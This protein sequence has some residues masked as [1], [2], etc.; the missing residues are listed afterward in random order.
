MTHRE[1]FN[2]IMHYGD[3]DRIPVIHWG[4]WPETIER[5]QAEGMPADVEQQE[6]FGTV[7][8]WNIL[9]TAIDLR[10]AFEVETIEENDRYRIYRNN[11][12]VICKEHRDGASSIPH[13][14]DYTFKDASNWPEFKRRLQPEPSRIPDNTDEEIDRLIAAEGPICIWGGSIMGLI[15]NWMGVENM[16][17]LVMDDPDV[18]ADMTMTMADLACWGFD[19]VLPRL[20]AKGETADIAFLWEDMCGRQGPLISPDTFRR[21]VAPAYRKMREKLDGYGVKLF[22]LDSDGDVR[23]L[24]RDWVD[25]GVNVMFPLEVG[26]MKMDAN[27]IRRE[28]GKELRLVGNFDKMA[29]ERG[30]ADVEAE[31]QRLMPLIR[32]GGFLMSPDHLITPGV[33]LDAYKAYLER[34]K[35][36]RV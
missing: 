1:L 2:A 12:G 28:Y 34:V 8:Y 24:L 29:I 11:E 17:Y 15:R 26:P 27:E 6:Y 19:Q 20:A 30:P 33:S 13:F 5:W 4:G 18:Y 7:P 31:I 25:V 23:P 22:G 21:C 9:W 14:L 32:D 35:A 16:A 36:I 10:P 3:F